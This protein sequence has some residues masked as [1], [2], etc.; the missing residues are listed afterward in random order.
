LI[1][2]GCGKAATDAYKKDHNGFVFRVCQSIDGSF[3]ENISGLAHFRSLAAEKL[4]AEGDW[5][6]DEFDD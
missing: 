2:L 1:S 3:L 6:D 4:A 5:D